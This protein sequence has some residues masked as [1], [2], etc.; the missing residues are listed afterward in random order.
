[1]R[2]HQIE[3]LTD[4]K[5]IG[6]QGRVTVCHNIC[7]DQHLYAICCI[8][9]QLWPYICMIKEHYLNLNSGSDF[10]PELGYETYT[11]PLVLRPKQACLFIFI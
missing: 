3:W 6:Q 8:E 2:L 5:N 11:P 1:M 9:K 7:P 4:R 10:N